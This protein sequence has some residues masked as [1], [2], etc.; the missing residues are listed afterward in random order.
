MKKFIDAV[1]EG[2]EGQDVVVMEVAVDLKAAWDRPEPPGDPFPT[3]PELPP[4]I[5]LPPVQVAS[6]GSHIEDFA[7]NYLY[8]NFWLPTPRGLRY[9]Q[10][11]GSKE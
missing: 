11:A 6:I 10:K 8:V 3:P 1:G 7:V 2:E 5:E 9:F 4:I